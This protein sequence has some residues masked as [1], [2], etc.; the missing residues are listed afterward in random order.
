MSQIQAYLKSLEKK[1]ALV[2]GDSM[3]D[4]YIHGHVSRI[5]PE[6]PVPVLLFED[7]EM[8]IGGAANVALNVQSLGGRATL[9]SAIGNDNSGDAFLAAMK[10]ANLDT[11]NIIRMVRPTT[12]KTRIMS[13]SQHLL[14]VDEEDSS[15]IHSEEEQA[16]I[17]HFL[18]LLASDKPDV[19]II[20]D[21]NKGLLTERLIMEILREAGSMDIPVCVDPKAL[22]FFAYT[23]VHIFKPNLAEVRGVCPFEVRVDLASLDQTDR[24]L[25]KQLAHEITIITL[26]KDGI[27]LNDGTESVIIGT[28]SREIVD[29]C[30]AGDAVIAAISLTSGAD[31]PLADIGK[32]GNVAGG[33]VC[34]FVGVAPI[35]RLRFLHEFE[36]N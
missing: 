36:Q 16:I 30:G 15:Q 31:L 2:I 17:S 24:Y 7:S 21:Y 27:Y 6:A 1:H 29:V 10:E 14:R 13:A 26:G 4:R 11:G 32:V 23:G 9:L 20:Q 19:I 8:K 34:A 3:L 25:R 5:S 33:L 28:E 35:P 18:Q 12:V 22:H